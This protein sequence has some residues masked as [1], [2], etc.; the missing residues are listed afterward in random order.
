MV[1]GE[2]SPGILDFQD[3]VYGPVT[4]DL[5]SLVRDCYFKFPDAAIS[6][7]VNRFREMLIENNRMT[8]VDETQ[9]RRWFD[10]MG[11]QRHIKCAGIFSRLNIRDGKPGYLADIPLVIRYLNE[12]CEPYPELQSFKAWLSEV[13]T[14]RLQMEAFK[15]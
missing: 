13:V 6:R 11:L 12:A 2:R 1:M 14:P 4:Y 8:M 9:F 10:L 15:R 7:Y 5:V 3:A